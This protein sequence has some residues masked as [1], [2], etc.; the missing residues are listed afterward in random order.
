MP[1][2][3]LRPLTLQDRRWFET[4]LAKH[5][6]SGD[7]LAA[8]SF[9]YHVIWQ[10]LFKF[11]W[12][13]LEGHVCLLA[14]NQE[15]S[16]LALPPLGSDPCGPV[17]AKAF[18]FLSQRN[19]TSA[20][21]RIENAPESLA[22]QCRGLCYRVTSKGPDYL[23]WRTDLV[24]LRGD[25]YKSQRV[26]YNHCVKEFRPAFRSY[27]PEDE[28]ASL[29]LFRH[30]QQGVRHDEA[31]DLAVRLAAD[32]ESAHCQGTSHAAELGL[33]GCVV[34]VEGRVKAYT[35]GYP[36]NASTFCVLFEI[37]DRQVKGLGA[38]VFREFCR[39][40]ESYEFINTMDDSGLDGLRRAKLS[41]H[42]IKLVESY[43]ISPSN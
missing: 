14:S 42:P 37:T 8:Y 4:V 30:W 35:F 10:D 31:S 13:E 43:I 41:Y 12:M 26:A 5:A 16:F 28:K 6:P 15:G 23:Y 34:E 2:P 9:P 33:V 36:L 21:T 7:P 24:A 3:T 40:L 27:R 38:Y 32:A 11:E 22:D 1:E 39:E 29:V 17:M 19:K 25:R 20:L 18:V